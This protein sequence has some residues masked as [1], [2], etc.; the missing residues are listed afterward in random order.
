MES[1]ESTEIL[2]KDDKLYAAISAIKIPDHLTKAAYSKDNLLNEKGNQVT[3]SLLENILFV[4][5]D[6]QEPLSLQLRGTKHGRLKPVKCRIP[7]LS[8]D[9]DSLNQAF[10]LIS[11]QF[12]PGRKSHVGNA[13]Q[14]FW[15]INSGGSFFPLEELRIENEV[16]KEKADY[17]PSNNVL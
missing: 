17:S 10:Y 6:L 12:E 4:E 14:R 9:A 8:K 16:K 13:F 11:S 15:I 5:V 1:Q 3:G 2:Q 7:S